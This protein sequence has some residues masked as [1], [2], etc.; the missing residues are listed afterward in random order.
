MVRQSPMGK[1]PPERVVGENLTRISLSLRIG[2]YAPKK[3]L[4]EN[5]PRSSGRRNHDEF[6]PGAER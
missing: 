1:S 5:Q 6:A 4:G 2:D 3:G